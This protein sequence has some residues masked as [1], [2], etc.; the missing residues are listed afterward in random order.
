MWY[1]AVEFGVADKQRWKLMKKRRRKKRGRAAGIQRRYKVAGKG[2]REGSSSIID[3]SSLLLWSMNPTLYF[4]VR[5][6]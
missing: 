5:D 1:W 4:V 3:S 6:D 2:E